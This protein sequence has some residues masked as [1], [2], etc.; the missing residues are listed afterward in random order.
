[1]LIE[2]NALNLTQ[3]IIFL[4]TDFAF[5]ISIITITKLSIPIIQVSHRPTDLRL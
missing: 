1:M 3:A 5:F 2:Q 4:V